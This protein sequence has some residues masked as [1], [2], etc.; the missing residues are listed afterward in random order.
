[1]SRTVRIQKAKLAPIINL[2]FDLPL[3]RTQA[4][5]RTKF[6][7][8]LQKHFEEYQQDYQDLLKEHCH[9]DEEGNP[10]MKDDN[11][12]DIKD[13]QAFLEDKKKLDEEE[14]VVEGGNVQEIL[15]TV[16]EVLLNCD[17]EF[18]G[19]DSIIYDYICDQFEKGVKD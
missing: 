12:P 19:Y 7:M 5:H 4:R 10:I 1:M 3:K 2:L 13:M 11:T 6:M 16:K 18:Q 8:I 15:K 17:K 14:V 9:L